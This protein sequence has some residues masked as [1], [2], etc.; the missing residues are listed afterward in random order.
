MEA[1]GCEAN[2]LDIR[3]SAEQMLRDIGHPSA[4]GA[5]VYDVTFENVQ[6]GERTSH[7]FRLANHRRALVVGTSD[8]SELALGWC[9]YGVGD[10]MSHYAR[11]RERAQDA[12]AARDP[13]GGRA[14]RARRRGE[15]G[16]ARDPRHRD[17]PRADPSDRWERRAGAGHRVGHRPVRAAGL[18]PLLRAPVRLRAPQGRLSRLLRVARLPGGLLAG[19]A[20]GPAPT[21]RHRPDQG[22]SCASSSIDSFA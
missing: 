1:V 5:A 21:V 15:R 10:H 9:T 7:L 4:E 11:E 19:R 18:Q 2:E 16:A 3:P 12:R 17:Q 13:L 20:A 22:R 6:A 8:L 14:R